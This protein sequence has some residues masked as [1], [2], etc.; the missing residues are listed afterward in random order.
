VFD[1]GAIVTRRAGNSLGWRIRRFRSIV[2]RMHEQPPVA[3][4]LSALGLPFRIFQHVG[5][6]ASLEQAAAE[7]GEAVGQVVRSIV[8]RLGAGNFVMVLMAGPGQISWPAL[9]GY[10]GQSRVSMASQDEVLAVT[11]YRVGAVSPLGLPQ[12]LRIL[13]DESVFLPDEISIGSG[14]RGI[15]VIL[16]SADLRKALPELEVGRF[17]EQPR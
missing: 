9:R 15:A 12:P 4:A 7:R 3:R 17:E 11:G 5:P 10:L 8:F 16:R 6:V 13:A 2:A 1:Q 14:E